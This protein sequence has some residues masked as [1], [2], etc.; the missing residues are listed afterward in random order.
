MDGPA[1]RFTLLLQISIIR[2]LDPTEELMLSNAAGWLSA[3]HKT[4]ILSGRLELRLPLEKSLDDEQAHRSR[5]DYEQDAAGRFTLN[6][7]HWT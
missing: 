6:H 7:G 4:L 5:Q 2:R 3:E 1:V